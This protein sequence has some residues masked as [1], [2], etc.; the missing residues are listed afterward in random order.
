LPEFDIETFKPKVPI[1]GKTSYGGLSGNLLR[2]LGRFAVAEIAKNINYNDFPISAIGGIDDL[3]STVEYIALGANHVQICSAVM[4][5][6][7][8]IIKSLI[9]ELSAYMEAHKFKNISEI[10]GKALQYIVPYEQLDKTRRVASVAKGICTLCK[11]CLNVCL[12]DAIKIPDGW[13]T[14]EIIEDKCVG[15]GSCISFCRA[16]GLEMKE[17][18]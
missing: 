7:F 18:W 14:I 10:R 5:N 11:R 13:K 15:C 3:N 1:G 16:G 6:G 17:I 4:N 8:D 2:P 12:Y 9:V